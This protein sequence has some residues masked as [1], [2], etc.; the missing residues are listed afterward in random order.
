MWARDGNELF[1]LDGNGYLTAVPVQAKAATFN[2]GAPS[3]I[4]KTRYY[5]G[6]SSR[7]YDLRA[8]DISPDGKRFLMIK[9]T[10]ATEQKSAAA[11]PSM[12]VVLNWHEEL[13]QRVPIR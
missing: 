1:Y 13:K 12:I 11:P 8:F 2:V 6:Y 10:E 3:Q 9:D 7:G 5:P 4:L